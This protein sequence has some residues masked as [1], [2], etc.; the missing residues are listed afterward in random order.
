MGG[1]TASAIVAN[2]SGG[3]LNTFLDVRVGDA[4]TSATSDSTYNLSGTGVI[5]SATGGHVGRQ[6]V[7][8]FFQSG[9]IANFN[10][11]F[12][13]GN[14]EAVTGA[15]DGLYEI[16]AGDLNF[17]AN[18]NIATSGIG[19]FRVVGDDGTID[20]AGA[21]NLNTSANGNGTLAYKLEPGDGLSMINVLGAATFAAGTSLV[22]DASAV[23]PTQTSYDLLTA[24]SI[25]D[26]GLA[27]TGP[28]TWTHQ[29]VSGGLGQILRVSAAASVE[30]ADF[31]QD[32][33]V[34]GADFLTWQ[35]G[36]GADS[37][38]TLATGDANGDGVINNGDFDIWKGQFGE[39]TVA[40]AI[41]EPS[42]VL[43]LLSS[44]ATVVAWRRRHA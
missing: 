9:G 30:D 26:N 5:N 20:V 11:T 18:L 19:Q 13:I 7:G 10:G 40:A 15:N 29:I 42:S 16:S 1:Q 25:T 41:P 6:G 22:L 37:G 32:G 44:F 12:N 36:F 24:A 39:S 35:R 14:R 3:T 27:F 43:L 2:H 8:K 4:S 34:D 31:D 28:A 17:G 33:D 23:S 38:G 21:F